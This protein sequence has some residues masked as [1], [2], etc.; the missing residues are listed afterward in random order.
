M[1]RI[2]AVETRIVDV[3]AVRSHV[4]SVA[5]VRTMSF[6]VIT[7]RCTDGSAGWGEAVTIGGLS[8]SDESPE[9][10]K[11]AIDTY[12]APLLLG[13]AAD[14]IGGIT[15]VIDRN[16]VGN[17]FARNAVETALLDRRGQVLG[18]P[19]SGF[20]GHSRRT[21]LEVAWTLASGDTTV[22]IAEAEHMLAERRHRI[23]KLKVGKRDVRDD[24][25]HVHAIKSAL[26]EAATL[27][28][29]VNQAWDSVTA[30]Q[31]LASLADVIDLVEQ[32]LPV[33]DIAG[34]ARVR[35]VSPLPV[36]ADEA[37]QGANLGFALAAARAA[38][39]FAVKTSQ[40]GG[41]YAACRVAASASATGIGL[42]GGT[43]LE[44]GFGTA[45]S[46]QVFSTFDSLAWGSELFGPLL[47]TEEL[48]CVPLRYSDFQLE[49][50]T[51]PGVGASYN[52]DTLARL[53]RV[54]S[55]A[56]HRSL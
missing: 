29:D 7:L 15:A 40:S 18:L 28:I 4:L 13:A 53:T 20:L 22:D 46:A 30:T 25:A 44:S 51:G 26:G 34:L 8:Y 38:D 37:L 14:D 41:P 50:P 27:R 17:R 24:I 47:L 33:H 48:L 32:P 52:L 2:D 9:G 36:M 45:A 6:V 11:L 23:F 1:T 56:V 49:V 12:F 5:T 31:A 10:I 35:S 43:M 3:S 55:H 19:L 21:H 42:Y 54:G 16:I 39:V